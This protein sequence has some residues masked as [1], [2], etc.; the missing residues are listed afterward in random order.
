MK[1]NLMNN[2]VTVQGLHGFVMYSLTLCLSER[3]WE[4]SFYS[5]LAL[6]IFGLMMLAQ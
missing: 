4:P 6:I 3:L 5:L 2:L 1:R